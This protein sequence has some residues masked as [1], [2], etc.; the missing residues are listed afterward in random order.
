MTRGRVVRKSG[1][2]DEPRLRRDLRG[3]RARPIRA[4]AVAARKPHPSARRCLA[5]GRRE[6]EPPRGPR[7]PAI[8]I[9]CF[10]RTDVGRRRELNEDSL[11]CSEKD[12][13]CLLADGMGGR[14][15]G[16]VASSLCVS[17]LNSH[18]HKFFPKSL[19][20]RSI[21][22]GAMTAEV[23][24]QAFDG[25]IRDVNTIVY[26]FG[27]FDHRYRE[28]GTTLAL[29]YQQADFVVLAHVGD[30]RI[31]RIREGAAQQMTED[32]S[33][34]NAQVKVGLLTREQAERSSHRNIITRC[35]GTRAVVKPDVT[36]HPAVVGDVYLLC[37]DGLSDLVEPHEMAAVLAKQPDLRE[38][39]R[40]LIDLANER[41]GI[42]NITVVLARIEPSA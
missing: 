7:R 37:S 15:F 10:G 38:A 33:F 34:V 24:V 31:Y 6:A 11:H 14:D 19:E 8:R 18:L 5:P 2:R 9:T 40:A 35:I 16:E 39:V 23:V 1:G 13:V 30:S 42:D 41:G 21:A 4:I 27:S 25:W 32:H 3:D 36:V 22:G 29:L 26:E 28:M 17:T 12:G 20:G